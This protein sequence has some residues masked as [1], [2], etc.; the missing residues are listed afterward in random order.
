MMALIKAAIPGWAG[1]AIPVEL[2]ALVVLAPVVAVVAVVDA[3][4]LVLA[5][6]A[7]ALAESLELLELAELAVP[8]V[9]LVRLVPAVVNWLMSESVITSLA[10]AMPEPAPSPAVAAVPDDAAEVCAEQE[11]GFPT[12]LASTDS[13]SAMSEP[14]VDVWL[15]GV[16][17][18]KPAGAGNIELVTSV[19]ILRLLRCKSANSVRN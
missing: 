3:V 18:L 8:L 2:A 9:P 1:V 11:V 16:V 12:S 10:G 14:K 6:A 7:V 4:A 13:K 15:A 5:A 17:Q 19:I